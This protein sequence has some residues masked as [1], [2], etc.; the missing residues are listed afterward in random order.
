MNE[1]IPVHDNKSIR[2]N[3]VEHTSYRDCMAHMLNISLF[4]V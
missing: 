3:V 2:I 4:I 1:S